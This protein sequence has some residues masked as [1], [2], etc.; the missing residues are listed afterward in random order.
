LAAGLVASLGAL[1]AAFPSRAQSGTF[2][3][4]ADDLVL[5]TL[6][7]PASDPAALRLRSLAA[8]LRA[9]PRDP[10]VASELARENVALYRKH[11]DPRYLGR[12]EAALGAF[13]D[14]AAPPASVRLL[15]ATIRQSN[16]DFGRALADLDALVTDEPSAAQARLTRAVVLGV[17]GRYIEASRDC[18]TLRP[19]ASPL[20][21]AVCFAGA[22]GMTGEAAKAREALAL[23]L[24][25]RHENHEERAWAASVLG[26]LEQRLGL[27]SEA[28]GHFEQALADDPD[29][30]YTLASYADLLL[31]RGDPEAARRLL[32]PFERVDALLLRL[33]IA[34]RRLDAPNAAAHRREL[35]ERFAAA[36]LRGDALHRREEARFLLE[37]ADEPERALALARENFDVQREAWDA[38]VL[39]EAA[40]RLHAPEA[41]RPVRDFAAANAL[42]DRWV[43]DGLRALGTPP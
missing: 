43:V 34:E 19:L 21:V 40:R 31:D 26:E 5:E 28:A 22:R 8:R 7:L 11:S 33:A 23:E 4:A 36:R 39:L 1:A 12:A 41:A 24:A 14:D 9:N 13:W 27:T 16:H 17:L 35:A 18:D 3:P 25:R 6:P 20:V 29:D 30:A 42:T 2:V 32:A 38:R 37:L 15:R 10:D